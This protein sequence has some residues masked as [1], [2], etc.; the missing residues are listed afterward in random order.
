MW[1]SLWQF[2]TCGMW[3]YAELGTVKSPLPGAK[4]IKDE[5]LDNMEDRKTFRLNI[6]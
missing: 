6:R 5:S 1:K 2:V 4:S 3:L